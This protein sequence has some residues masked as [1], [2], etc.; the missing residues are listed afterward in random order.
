M[1]R[2]AQLKKDI[3]LSLATILTL[4][5]LSC[6]AG[7]AQEQPPA[8]VVITR[9]TQQEV[10]ENKSFLGVLYYDR[11]SHVS[12]EVAGLVAEMHVREGSRV[13]KGTPLVSLNTEILDKQIDLSKTKIGQVVL[14]IEHAEKNFKRLEKLFSQNSVSEKD[15]ED[16]LYTHQDLLK[17]K[18]ALEDSLAQLMIQKE[19]SV[20]KAPFEGIVLEKNVERGNWVQPG[21]LLVRLGSSDDLFVRVPISE[22]LLQFITFGEKVPV[23]IHAFQEELTG[24]LEGIDPT[25]DPQTKNIFLKVKIAARA[26]VAEN[27]SAAVFVPT[28][29][30]K[31]LSI[32]PRDALIK[33]QGKDFVY[34]IQ[35]NKA[36]ILPINIVTYLGE[37]IGADNPYFVTGMPVV[38]EG[39]ER[40]RPDQPATIAGEK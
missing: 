17:E 1:Q 16:A 9:I 4:I 13:K 24:T 15:Y 5:L 26:M 25:A 21:T 3:S 12:S 23:T 35:D 33:F 14:R 31:Q 40:L 36:S 19:K 10:S 29:T 22:N 20:I 39:N 11:V 32:I 28:S 7:L 27:M 37:K 38:I 18:E 8:Q 30:K 34:T 6:S 2:K